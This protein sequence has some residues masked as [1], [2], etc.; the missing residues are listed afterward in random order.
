MRC[1][2]YLK[3]HGTNLQLLARLTVSAQ[4]PKWTLS[5][6]ERGSTKHM[7][8]QIQFQ[9]F[10]GSDRANGFVHV[11]VKDRHTNETYPCPI[12][13]THF[14]EVISRIL[15]CAMEYRPL[16][17]A[18]S[19]LILDELEKISKV[20]ADVYRRHRPSRGD[21]DW[22]MAKAVRLYP[23]GSPAR[24][25]CYALKDLFQSRHRPV[26]VDRD[27]FL[28]GA[29]VDPTLQMLVKDGLIDRLPMMPEI[30]FMRPRD[31]EESQEAEVE[32]PADLLNLSDEKRELVEKLIR[33]LQDDPR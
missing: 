9:S 19:T 7:S 6:T 18:H 22:W 21:Y 16:K 17:E 2:E 26:W 25:A 14:D 27:D 32:R 28:G 23:D 3:I 30:V 13:E 31:H 20:Q 24:N 33:L 12:L 10:L 11:Y 8:R 4:P 15:C 29:D 1:S 5:I